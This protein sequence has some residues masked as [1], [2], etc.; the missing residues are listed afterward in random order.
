MSDKSLQNADIFFTDSAQQIQP[1]ATFGMQM[2]IIMG[3][4]GGAACVV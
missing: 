3:L 2:A 4:S 1:V